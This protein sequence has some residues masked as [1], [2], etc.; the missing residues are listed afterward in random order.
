MN[1]ILRIFAIIFGILF[2]VSAGLQYNDPDPLVWMLIWGLAGL[3]ALASAFNKVSFVIPLVTG[4]AA[5][6]GFFYLYPEKF[7]GFEIGA[8]DI[9]NI[10]EAREAF[11]FLIISIVLLVLAFRAWSV[12]KSKV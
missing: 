8:G 12:K 10:E 1:N 4:I 2:L 6:V 7:E 11:G 5:L 9:K 3:I